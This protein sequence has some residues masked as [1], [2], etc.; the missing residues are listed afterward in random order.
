ML[1]DRQGMLMDCFVA[2]GAMLSVP[3][4][5]DNMFPYLKEKRLVVMLRTLDSSNPAAGGRTA[6]AGLAKMP[7]GHPLGSWLFFFSPLPLQSD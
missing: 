1:Y 7:A 5:T 2:F 4:Q 6:A 3:F